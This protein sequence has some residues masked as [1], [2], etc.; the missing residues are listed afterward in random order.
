MLRN[1]I[2]IAALLFLSSSGKAQ[3]WSELGRIGAG[4]L[5]TDSAAIAANGASV[6]A[7]T[8]L[9]FK[10]PQDTKGALGGRP[11]LSATM[12]YEF[13]CHLG[14]WRMLSATYYSRNMGEGDVISTA[15]AHEGWNPIVAGSAESRLW[16]YRMR[17]FIT[18]RR[19]PASTLEPAGRWRNFVVA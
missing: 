2:L 7:W 1:V 9:D 4:V 15:V 8:L 10:S 6:V 11:H 19:G 13:D 12:Q 5:Y 14:Q 18:F 16:G 17:H 3:R